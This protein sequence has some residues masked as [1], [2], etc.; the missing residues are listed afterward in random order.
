MG[1]ENPAFPAILRLP[2]WRVGDWPSCLA[3][4]SRSV[5]LD[6]RQQ[7]FSLMV[8]GPGKGAVAPPG[9]RLANSSVDWTLGAGP[10]LF[11]ARF[12]KG[13]GSEGCPTLSP[14]SVGNGL[15]SGKHGQSGEMGQSCAGPI[16]ASPQKG[17]IGPPHHPKPNLRV[18]HRGITHIDCT[19]LTLEVALAE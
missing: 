3:G 11:S 10:M 9:M 14:V 12:V 5:P 2:D 6:R 16:Q 1:F 19:G 4:Q 7:G 17:L 8:W 13:R 18:D 15:F